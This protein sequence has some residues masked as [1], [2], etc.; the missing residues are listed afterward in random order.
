MAQ[1]VP[2]SKGGSGRDVSEQA[3]LAAVGQDHRPV[4]NWVVVIEAITAS[5]LASFDF[6]LVQEL[7]AQL[8]DWQPT[9]L[10]NPDRYAIQLHVGAVAAYEA[11]RVAVTYH[12]RA[13]R[14]VGLAASL[15]RAEVL[16]L[17]EFEAGL[18]D[19]VPAR[20][21]AP[22]PGSGQVPDRLGLVSE[23]LYTATRELLR[24]STPAQITE[25]LVRFVTSV[26]GSVRVGAS[27]S[28][29]GMFAVEL[30][31]G[32][33]GPLFAVAEHMSVAGMIIEQSLPTLVADAVMARSR[34]Q[35]TTR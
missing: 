24:V 34:L 6:T 32:D 26:G 7:V 27:A 3:D 8:R 11:L 22:G 15:S 33:G 17:D 21:V 5:P 9:G 12:D 19:P 18:L 35:E 2:G 23:D 14:V 16:T 4:D 28:A 20:L 10:Y 25:L 30:S 31:T 13:L 29:P 1:V